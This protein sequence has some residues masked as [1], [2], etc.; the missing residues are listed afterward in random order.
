MHRLLFDET[1]YDDDEDRE[2]EHEAELRRLQANVM[3]FNETVWDR[4]DDAPSDDDEDVD[5]E[6]VLCH[7]VRRPSVF[8]FLEVAPSGANRSRQLSY[9][10]FRI[11][12]HTLH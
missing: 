7:D 5:W 2:D 3:F 4:R 12:L 8:C 9:L 6:R 10:P 11:C 1:D